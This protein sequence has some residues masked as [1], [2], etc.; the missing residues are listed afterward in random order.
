MIIKCSTFPPYFSNFLFTLNYFLLYP[1]LYLLSWYILKVVL[2]RAYTNGM[3]RSYNIWTFRDHRT[4]HTAGLSSFQTIQMV[5]TIQDRGLKGFQ[6]N[7]GTP[8]CIRDRV[9]WTCGRFFFVPIEHEMTPFFLFFFLR[10][11]NIQ[12]QLDSLAI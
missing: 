4:V 12:N 9:L 6:A 3:V 2:A 5:R 8:K 1:P 7:S 11:M 10:K